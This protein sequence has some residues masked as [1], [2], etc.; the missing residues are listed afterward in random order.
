MVVEALDSEDV[1]SWVRAQI[2]RSS[3]V[4]DIPAL[5]LHAPWH[6]KSTRLRIL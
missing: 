5:Q 6:L 3:M 2:T 1:Q 4:E